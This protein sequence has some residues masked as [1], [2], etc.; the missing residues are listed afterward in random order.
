MWPS[1]VNRRCFKFSKIRHCC[2]LLC[3][4]IFVQFFLLGF[5]P[6][7]EFT[8]QKME[9]KSNKDNPDDVL[10]FFHHEDEDGK[11]MEFQII[12]K[13]EKVSKVQT[14][15]GQNKNPTSDMELIYQWADETRENVEKLNLTTTDNIFKAKQKALRYF[16]APKLSP[17]KKS[18]L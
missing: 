18:D 8:F 17:E 3:L 6:T 9:E 13:I 7:L 14:K 16:F 2:L 10:N 4:L 5:Y 15:S 11:K 12:R 1:L